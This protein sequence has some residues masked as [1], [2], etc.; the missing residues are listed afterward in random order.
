MDRFKSES[1]DHP[2][3]AFR[4]TGHILFGLGVKSC[5]KYWQLQTYINPFTTSSFTRLIASHHHRHLLHITSDKEM[6]NIFHSIFAL[7][8][9]ISHWL[10]ESG[11]LNPN[12]GAWPVNHAIY[13]LA[14]NPFLMQNFRTLIR[15][16]DFP[17]THTQWELGVVGWA[18]RK[19]FH[20]SSL[21]LRPTETN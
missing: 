15:N 20:H 1:H 5:W 16:E 3:L 6:F 14:C 7:S 2:T 9:S 8:V 21:G 17:H 11:K 13:C 18:G 4:H 10:T 12:P 19:A